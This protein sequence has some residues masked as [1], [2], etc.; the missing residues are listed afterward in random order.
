MI[1]IKNGCPYGVPW[2]PGFFR[3]PAV[4]VGH[5]LRKTQ[6]AHEF[7][8]K[9][10][11][12][13]GKYINNFKNTQSMKKLKTWGLWGPMGSPWAPIYQNIPKMHKHEQKIFLSR[14]KQPTNIQMACLYT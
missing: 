10:I 12:T 5:N 6:G 7:N 4:L 1:K 2:G 13:V 8:R 11:K 3:E 14:K 9:H